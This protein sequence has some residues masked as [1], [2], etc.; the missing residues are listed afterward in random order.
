MATAFGK[1]EKKG[2]TSEISDS[3]S[4]FSVCMSKNIQP[5][6]TLSLVHAPNTTY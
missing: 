4:L 5:M 2:K 1:E 3:S 6:M